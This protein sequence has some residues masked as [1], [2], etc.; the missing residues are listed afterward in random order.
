MQVCCAMAKLSVRD[1][2]CVKRIGRYLAGKPRA[3]CWFHWKQSGE[4]KAYSD[5][6]WGGDKATRRSVCWSHH[7]RQRLFESMDQEAAVVSL[8]TTES[9][10]Y[11]ADKT[12]SGGI[13]NSERGEGPGHCMWVEPTSGRH[14]HH[15]LRDHENWTHVLKCQSERT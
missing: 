15:G 4:L 6:D 7:E 5:A 9:E 1:L 11:A 13:G 3:K 2:E 10:L 8:S 14:E 12:A